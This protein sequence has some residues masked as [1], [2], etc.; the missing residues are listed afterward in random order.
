MI[1]LQLFLSF[2]QIGLFGFGGGY[3]MLSLLQAEIV[4]RHEW[5]TASEFADI[6]AIS[7][8]T[9][10]P[11]SINSATYIGYHTSGSVLGAAVATFALC[12]PSLILMFFAS[13]FY[14]R[15]KN[16]PYVSTTIRSLRPVVVGMILSA[17]LLLMTKENFIDY[18][19]YLIFALALLAI[20]K[21]ANPLLVLTLAGFAGYLLF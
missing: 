9:P 21:K 17:A 11:I 6:V 20:I 16:N 5:L 2:F 3:A 14:T 1:Y 19:S 13:L 4:T 10:G 18:R 7:Q 12:L 15:L 8:M